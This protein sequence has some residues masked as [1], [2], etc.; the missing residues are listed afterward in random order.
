MG[1]ATFHPQRIEE[2][3][4]RLEGLPTW[5]VPFPSPCCDVVVWLVYRTTEEELSWSGVPCLSPKCDRTYEVH[6]FASEQVE[7][8]LTVDRIHPDRVQMLC[9]GAETQI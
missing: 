3:R 1:R 4:I 6:L 7:R 2:N 8:R 5:A 9:W